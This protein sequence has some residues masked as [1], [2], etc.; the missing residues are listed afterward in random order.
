MIQKKCLVIRSGL[1]IFNLNSDLL[2]QIKVRSDHEKNDLDQDQ[3]N[4]VNLQNPPSAWPEVPTAAV[5]VMRLVGSLATVADLNEP[6]H[7]FLPA[8]GATKPGPD[9][10]SNRRRQIAVAAE[11]ELIHDR[12]QLPQTICRSLFFVHFRLAQIGKSFF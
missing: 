1:S 4:T 6:G 5:D 10:R 9:S 11:V 8:D 2:S 7:H 3:E 12:L